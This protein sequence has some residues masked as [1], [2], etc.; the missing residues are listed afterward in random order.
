MQMA[1]AKPSAS[2][3][4]VA[5]ADRVPFLWVANDRCPERWSQPWATGDA[6]ENATSGWRASK[7]AVSERTGDWSGLGRKQLGAQWPD[8]GPVVVPR[9]AA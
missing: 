5:C 8:T 6:L 9:V 1:V 4:S 7:V 3:G 2:R